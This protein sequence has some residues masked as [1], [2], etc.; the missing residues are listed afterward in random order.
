MYANAAGAR[1]EYFWMAEA[2][3]LGIAPVDGRAVNCIQCGVCEEKCPQNIPISQRM[4]VVH[5]VLGEEKPY[6]T[7]L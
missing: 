3:R 5:N 2:H 4:P 6:Q 1:G 7:A